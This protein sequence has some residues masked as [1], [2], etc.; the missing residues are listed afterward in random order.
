MSLYALLAGRAEEYR[1]RGA[2]WELGPDSYRAYIHVRPRGATPSP[3]DRAQHLI[4]IAS[5]SEQE[6]LDSAQA[7]VK[8]ALGVS[9]ARLTLRRVGDRGSGR[10]P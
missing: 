9:D 1:I 4:R 10:R 5:S 3:A 6:I 8:L 2:I 7:R